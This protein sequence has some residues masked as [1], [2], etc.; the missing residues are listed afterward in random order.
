MK[1]ELAERR[2][3]I[4]AKYICPLC[5][6]FKEGCELGLETPVEA[7]LY[8]KQARKRPARKKVVPKKKK[9]TLLAKWREVKR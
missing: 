7:C 1:P 3:I 6:S 8:Y 9:R 2:A 5:K 4:D